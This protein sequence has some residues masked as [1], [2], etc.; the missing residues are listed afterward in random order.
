MSL[1]Q[2]AVLLVGIF[3]ILFSQGP[4]SA[5]LTLIFGIAVCVLVLAEVVLAHRS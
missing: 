4:V 1:T 2:I 5:T 3:L